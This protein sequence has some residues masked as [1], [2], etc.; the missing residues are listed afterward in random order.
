MPHRFAVRGR[1]FSEHFGKRGLQSVDQKLRLKIDRAGEELTQFAH[2]RRSLRGEEF[3]TRAPRTMELARAE[4]EGGQLCAAAGNEIHQLRKTFVERSF[5]AFR[6]PDEVSDAERG[7]V[8]ARVP[9]SQ[10]GNS[11]VAFVLPDFVSDLLRFGR[12][13]IDGAEGRGNGE[14]SDET[15]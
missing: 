7:E 10:A 3:L 4:E 9:G 2:L 15:R 8:L 14:Q 5:P 13:Q 11:S 1:C 12:G 6:I